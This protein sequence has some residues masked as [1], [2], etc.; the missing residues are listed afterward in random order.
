[1]QRRGI[2]GIEI[3]PPGNGHAT[4]GKEHFLHRAR[5]A[6]RGDTKFNVEKIED[7]MRK[8]SP[9]RPFR[10]GIYTTV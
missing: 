2:V 6:S 10:L 7:E 1:M 4:E 5:F 9:S 3:A 8:E